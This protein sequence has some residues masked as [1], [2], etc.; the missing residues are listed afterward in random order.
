MADATFGFTADRPVFCSN[1][2][3]L[4]AEIMRADGTD[5][6]YIFIRGI[7]RRVTREALERRSGLLTV[8]SG[9]AAGKV[10]L[11]VVGFQPGQLNTAAWLR[12]VVVAVLADFGLNGRVE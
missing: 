1:V 6:E 3:D 12:A 9:R 8:M 2:G 10:I 5:A 11:S 4:P 7:D